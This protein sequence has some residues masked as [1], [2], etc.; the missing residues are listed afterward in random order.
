[1]TREDWIKRD[2]PRGG[3]RWYLRGSHGVVWMAT[4]PRGDGPTLRVQVGRTR[5]SRAARRRSSRAL[6]AMRAAEG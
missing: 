1:M 3:T 4:F 5:T 2:H 6:D